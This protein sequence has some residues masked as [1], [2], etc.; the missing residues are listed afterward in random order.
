MEHHAQLAFLTTPKPPPSLPA[1]LDVEFTEFWKRWPHR[2]NDPKK[3]ARASYER[4][5]RSASA[6]EILTGV[7]TY[8]FSVDPK[9]RPMAC[10]WLNQARYRCVT[11]DLSLDAWGVDE[12]TTGLPTREGFSAA[13]YEREALD[14]I[15]LA[16][17]WPE[18]WRGPL[19]VLDEWL[20]DGYEPASIAGVILAA[21]ADSGSRASL[22]AY[23]GI[24][25]SRAA[26]YDAAS[27]RYRSFSEQTNRGA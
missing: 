10:T 6:D 15:M 9:Y 24:V 19:D 20:R 5:R 12:F 13:A 3:P 18:T 25:R 7:S 8:Q 26:R 14:R 27:F 21:V 1:D 4:A 23:D 2:P 22:K 16:T 11:V 17:C